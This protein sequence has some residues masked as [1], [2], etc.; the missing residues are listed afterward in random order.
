MSHVALDM[1]WQDAMSDLMEIKT[2]EQE[3][4]VV[5]EE[6]GKPQIENPWSEPE[7]FEHL[8]RL[9]VKYI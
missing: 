1:Q 2:M 5:N 6:T 7:I 4:G 8:G 3:P 9:Y